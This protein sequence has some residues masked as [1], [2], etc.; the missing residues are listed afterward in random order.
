MP[1]KEKGKGGGFK[2]GQE[3]LNNA[4]SCVGRCGS[5][6]SRV[7]HK[8]EHERPGKYRRRQLWVEEKQQ[9]RRN[10]DL[11]WN[12]PRS[13]GRLSLSLLLPLDPKI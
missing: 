4:A 3:S 1:N 5:D 11:N 10:S 2:E 9:S 8:R 13:L 7:A 12:I 6:H